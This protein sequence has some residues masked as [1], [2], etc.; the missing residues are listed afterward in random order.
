M[1]FRLLFVASLTLMVNAGYAEVAFPEKQPE[2]GN[3]NRPIPNQVVD[4]SPPG[5]SWWRAA[6]R[7]EVS[8][9][10]SIDSDAGKPVYVSK[11]QKDPVYVP[12]EVLAQG[13][14]VW[15]VEAVNKQGETVAIRAPQAFTVADDALDLPWVD[16]KTLLQRVELEHPRLLFPKAQLGEV[17]KTLKGERKLAFND[18]KAMADTAL[19]MELMVKP[20]FDKYDIEKE[21]PARRTA[22]RASYLK[23][24]DVY[25]QGMTPLALV[26]LMT[27]EEKYGLAAK[28]HLLHVLDWELE[29]IGSLDE[30][31]D[32]IGLRIARTAAQGY[33][34]LYDL[35]TEEERKAVKKMLLARGDQMLNRLK[36]RDYLNFSIYSHDGRLP[37]YLMEFAIVLAEEERTVEWLDYALK[38]WL[39]VY[40]HWG[41]SE[42]GWAEGVHYAMSYND[43]FI[44]P[45]QSLYVAT[46][47]NLW[48]KAYL[49]NMRHFLT[50][51]VAPLGEVIPFG[52]MEHNPV[53]NYAGDLYSILTFHA[54][55]YGDAKA[56]WWA[57][58]Y[59]DQRMNTRRLG[60]MHR[61]I[62]P[63]AIGSKKPNKMPQDKLFSGIGWAALH[64]D[65]L[66]PT[67]DVML[68]FK[69][70]P[71]GSVSHSHADQNSF[72]I[73]KGGK[74]L[75][76]PSGARFPQH[77]SPFHVEY[78]RQTLAH[79]ALLINGEGQ[80]DRDATATGGIVDFHS[81][82]HLGY[83]VGE[84][85]RTY[86]DRLDEYQRHV[87]MIR[88]S[89]V[90][91]IDDMAGPVPFTV[92]WLLHSKEAMHLDQGKQRIDSTRGDEKMRTYLL[93]QEEL[94]F[95]V[96]NRWPVDPK[97]DY[98]MVET[99][100]PANEWHFSA[101]SGSQAK[102]KVIAAVML[103]A[104]KG[105]YP[106]VE[107][108]RKGG[109]ITLSGQVGG[110]HWEAVLQLNSQEKNSEQLLD[111]WYQT[112]EEGLPE[113]IKIP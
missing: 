87:V 49:R 95:T 25:T 2:N 62:H 39:T 77:F 59:K 100:V 61:L 79:N 22:Y 82:E 17:K 42:G 108:T 112:A 85:E 54:L 32:E 64:S 76:H 73:M 57:E 9:R 34:W 6:P 67:S 74:A 14:Y 35:L 44:T 11:L 41:G 52:D 1:K 40:P 3:F 43:R 55:N 110:D 63:D 50:Y 92:D 89:V 47:Y 111:L 13:E 70:S 90:L 91:I 28:K 78:T 66:N 21:Y 97:K 109:K 93:A 60:A 56:R 68:L 15:R 12:S 106:D 19:T 103:I 99:P 81:T 107:M 7:G 113:T 30:G 5:F 53:S 36:G 45:L 75:A 46:G 96:S 26:Y 88:P 58:Q 18:L 84:A 94:E 102:Q 31:F 10:L 105:V 8:Y 37:G 69:S 71:F 16:P 65:I 23:F 38:A 80:I 86:G 27:G 48:N 101:H 83:V 29:G 51:A 4:V 24:T 98:P 72:A 104:D 20:D 33:D